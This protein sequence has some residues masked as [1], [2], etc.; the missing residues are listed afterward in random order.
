MAGKRKSPKLRFNGRYYVANVY[1]PDGKRTTVSF[2]SASD[3]TEGAVY[4]AFG[5]WLDLFT[6]QPQKV[7]SFKSPYDA[8]EEIVS[9][10]TIL[11]VGQLLDKY[12]VYAKKTLRPVRSNK[13]HPDVRFIIRA[14]QFLKPYYDWRISDF[15]PDELQAVQDEMLSHEYTH[16]SKR[17]RYTRRGINDTINWIRKIWKW[18]MGRQLVTAELVQGLNEVKSLRMGETEAPDNPK[19][20]RVTQGEFLKVARMANAVVSDMLRLIWYT[21]MRPQEV[22]EIRACDILRDDSDCW[23]YVPGRDGTP[24]GKHKTTRFE[25]VRVIPLTSN[26][27]KILASRLNSLDSTEY[28]FSPKEAVR[29]FFERRSTNRETP[30]SCGNRPGT[31][32]RKH[33][34]IK[35]GDR[36]TRGALSKACKRACMRAGV[37]EFVP[38]DLRRT[39]ATR[40]RAVLGK[41]GARLLLGHV[42]TDTTDIY[43]LEE[44]QEAVKVAKILDSKT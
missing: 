38:Y 13:E 26:C 9:P 35:P 37:E 3:R 25:R 30:L 2:G 39:A 28:I 14:K 34:M 17:K 22:C 44:V 42:N 1:R 29:E 27:Q 23:L 31:N 20:R 40:A 19:R 15:G 7:L 8:V 36:Y 11:T 43:L 18:G 10:T 21:A 32:R 5:R 4:A 41:E 12:L 24:V 33:P 6:R 16:G